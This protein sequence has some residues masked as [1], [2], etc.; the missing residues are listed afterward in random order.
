MPDINA[1]GPKPCGTGAGNGSAISSN[2]WSA[3][4]APLRG[5]GLLTDYELEEGE[6][7]ITE[8]SGLHHCATQYFH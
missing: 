7:C 1:Y 6:G 2:A 3:A 4:C 5:R 8:E